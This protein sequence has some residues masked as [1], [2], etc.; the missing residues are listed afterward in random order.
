MHQYTTCISRNS[1]LC[2]SCRMLE[3]ERINQVKTEIHQPIKVIFHRNSTRSITE[4]G[5]IANTNN[6]GQRLS[7]IMVIN[8]Q[9]LSESG[10]RQK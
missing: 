5:M 6:N 4:Q 2:P 3:A 9:H 7:I 8:H 1:F 10:R